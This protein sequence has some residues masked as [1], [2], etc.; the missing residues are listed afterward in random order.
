MSQA[1]AT[2]E[3]GR[4]TM[5]FSREETACPEE[6]PGC[7]SG[8]LGL[9]SHHQPSSPLELRSASELRAVQGTDDGADDRITAHLLVIDDD[10]A[11]TPEQWRRVFPAPTHRV[12][13]AGA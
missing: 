5:H 9:A 12:R 2:R 7:R 10:P 4:C 1:V 8:A 6:V 11:A 3:A 13:V